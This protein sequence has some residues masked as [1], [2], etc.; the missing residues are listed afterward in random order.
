MIIAW[1][2]PGRPRVMSGLLVAEGAKCNLCISTMYDNAHE[3]F[4]PC[5]LERMADIVDFTGPC[6]YI[7]T[8]ADKSGYWLVSMHESMHTYVGIWNGSIWVWAHLPFGMAPACQLYTLLKQEVY[9][10]L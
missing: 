7:Y 5:K 8:T 6:D 4:V 10:P 1:T 9:H 3:E 2:G